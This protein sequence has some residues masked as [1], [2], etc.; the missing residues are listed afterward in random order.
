MR[1]LFIGLIAVC[2]LMGCV[3]AGEVL[4]CECPN[5]DIVI[6]GET[7]VEGFLQ[8]PKGA[9]DNP[10]YFWTVPEFEADMK[11]LREFQQQGESI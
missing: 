4:V 10:D 2:F 3:T 1:K 6:Q 9:F 8:I 5:Q 7:S 11:E